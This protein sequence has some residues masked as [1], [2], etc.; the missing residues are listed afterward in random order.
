MSLCVVPVWK[1][2]FL[3]RKH[4]ALAG[5]SLAAVG[6]SLTFGVSWQR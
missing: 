3:L 5:Q 6:A 1:L 2:N 4:G